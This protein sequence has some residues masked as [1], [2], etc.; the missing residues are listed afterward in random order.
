MSLRYHPGEFLQSEAGFL[1]R[2][3][4]IGGEE[5]HFQALPQVVPRTDGVLLGLLEGAAYDQAHAAVVEDEGVDPARGES[6]RI[7]GKV[8]D[9]AVVLGG[10]GEGRVVEQLDQVAIFVAI[11]GA[12]L[13]RGEQGHLCAWR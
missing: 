11:A 8:A 9:H 5:M 6:Q 12:P 3:R 4:Q 2:R 1:V 7:G 13:A 10:A